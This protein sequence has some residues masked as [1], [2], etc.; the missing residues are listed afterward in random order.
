MIVNNE[1]DV[2]TSGCGL[3]VGALTAV[4]WRFS[5]RAIG[6]VFTTYFN[7]KQIKTQI[8]SHTVHVFNMILTMNCDFFSQKQEAASHCNRDAVCSVG[9]RGV[10]VIG[11]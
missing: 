3:R 1:L 7:S 8:V 10:N 4:A 11:G 9:F 2:G 5:E 6:T